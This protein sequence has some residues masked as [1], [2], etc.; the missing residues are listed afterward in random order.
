MFKGI[1]EK[2]KKITFPRSQRPAASARTITL[3]SNI[4]MCAITTELI[5]YPYSAVFEQI[6]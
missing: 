6:L 1:L 3:E 2:N 4:I 5:I